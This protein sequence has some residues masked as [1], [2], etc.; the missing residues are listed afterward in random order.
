MKKGMSC[1]I[2]ELYDHCQKFDRTGSKRTNDKS[3]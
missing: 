1:E 2:N 3:N